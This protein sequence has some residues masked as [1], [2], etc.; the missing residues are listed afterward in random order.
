VPEFV[1]D[2]I[3]YH[4][5]LHKKHGLRWSGS[6]AH[7]HTPEFRRDERRFPGMAEAERVLRRIAAGR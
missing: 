2:F 1:V 5:L 4:E 3:V 6:R 7:A